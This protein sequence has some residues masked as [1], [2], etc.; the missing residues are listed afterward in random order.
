M[1]VDEETRPETSASTSVL[2]PKPIRVLTMSPMD[3][4]D[5]VSLTGLVERVPE[6]YPLSFGRAQDLLDLV[7]QQEISRLDGLLGKRAAAF[8]DL[9][10]VLLEQREGT[11]DLLFVV[12]GDLYSGETVVLQWIQDFREALRHVELDFVIVPSSVSSDIERSRGARVLYERGARP[13]GQG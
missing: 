11:V 2:G 3:F 10:R 5:V 1:V 7:R 6:V 8:D 13:P 12:S 4:E 9:V